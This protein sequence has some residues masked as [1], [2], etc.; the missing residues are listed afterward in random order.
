[1]QIILN[2]EHV[3]WL[4]NYMTIY[5]KNHQEA[6]LPLIMFLRGLSTQPSS[7]V[8]ADPTL[9]KS[10]IKVTPRTESES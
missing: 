10:K 2:E 8:E 5:S 9:K 6:M 4:E 1:M 7:Q 3:K